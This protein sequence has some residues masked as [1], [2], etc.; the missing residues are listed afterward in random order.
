M[1]AK[2]LLLLP[3]KPCKACF[4]FFFLFRVVLCLSAT[5]FSISRIRGGD[6]C[7][8]VSQGTSGNSFPHTQVRSCY[9]TKNIKDSKT[10][11]SKYAI[12]TLTVRFIFIEVLSFKS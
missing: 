11:E 10:I 6:P 4:P 5:F 1:S 12:L 2:H 3:C 8:D 7:A 9:S